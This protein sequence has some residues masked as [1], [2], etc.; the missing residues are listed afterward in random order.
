LGAPGSTAANALVAVTG[1]P[2][3][4]GAGGTELQ[5]SAG[6]RAT[7][8]G[9]KFQIGGTYL[10]AAGDTSPTD[11]TSIAGGTPPVSTLFR[12]LTV[13]GFDVNVQPVK[14]LG[15]SAAVTE[16]RWDGAT[17]VDQQFKLFGIS[18]NE[19]RAYDLRFK[20]PISRAQLTAYYK[21][22]G[23][24]FDAPGAW[25]RIGDWINPR[26]IEGVGGTLEVPLWRRLV[27]SLEGADYNYFGLHRA[28]GGVSSSDLVYVNGGIRFPL[29]SRNSVDFGYER[30][31]YE[32][33]GAAGGA[34]PGLKRLEQY[35]NIGFSHQFN[36][37]LSWRVLYQFMD[38]HSGGILDEPGFHYQA[39]IIATQ[40]QVRF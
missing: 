37:G 30:A 16:S 31:D 21:R 4:V 11:P 29:T 2:Y 24:G 20:V 23:E 26:G 9:K 28:L 39:G 35:Y 5:Q 33:N 18:E 25:G 7:Y 8:V 40:F 14:W 22:I 10:N 19:R 13:E 36:P 12:S 34:V 27:L 32:P 3:T 6:V 17:G 15:I 38:V 1:T